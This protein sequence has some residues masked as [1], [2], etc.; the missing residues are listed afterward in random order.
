MQEWG[1]HSNQTGGYFQCNR[2]IG[3][4]DE[5]SSNNRYGNNEAGSSQMESIRNKNKGMRMARFIHHY[6]RYQAHGDSSI[7]ENKMYKETTS[8]ISDELNATKEGNISWLQGGAV[9]S[10]YLEKKEINEKKIEINEKEIEINLKDVKIFSQVCVSTP[11][12]EIHSIKDKNSDEIYLLDFLHN[13]FRELL[14][15]RLALRGSF[16]YAFFEFDSDNNNVKYSMLLLLLLL[17]LLLIIIII[18]HSFI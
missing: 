7:M 4:E 10:P 1:L 3:N 11:A 2:F 13:G 17:L 12:K 5:E 8:R 14:K 9:E 15:C 18:N 6:S 16:S